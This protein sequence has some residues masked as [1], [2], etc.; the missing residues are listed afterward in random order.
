MLKKSLFW[1]VL[2]CVNSLQVS[3]TPST[4]LVILGDSLSA[5]YGMKQEQG[6]VSLL[7]QRFVQK[8]SPYHIINASISGETT[9]G[10]LA[11]LPKILTKHSVDYLIIELGGND[12]LRGF[13]IPLIKNNLLQII[14]LAKQENINIALMQIKIPP[15][16]GPKYNKLFI[17]N[18]QQLA[19]QHNIPLLDFFMEDIAINPALMLK[20]GIHPNIEAQSMIADNMEKQLNQ[21]L[22]SK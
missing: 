17:E 8:N 2:L 7:N 20:D 16:Y 9:A 12:G 22:L 15:N 4:S 1:V 18:Y 3:A 10:G 19:E 6:W 21:L 14:T 11:R 5:A 13:P